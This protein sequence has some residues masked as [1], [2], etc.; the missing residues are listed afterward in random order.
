MQDR[1]WGMSEI[2]QLQAENITLKK[3]LAAARIWLY[4][5]RQKNAKAMKQALEALETAWENDPDN[6]DGYYFDAAS[7]LREALADHTEQHLEMVDRADK[8]CEAN[9]VWTDHHPDCVRAEQPAQ[10]TADKSKLET[11]PANGGLLPAQQEENLYAYAGVQIWVGNTQAS[12][13]ISRTAIENEAVKGMCLHIAA[14]WCL[15]ELKERT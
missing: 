4:I 1:G 5:E 15:Q 2:E 8:F 10:S 6:A 14:D 12:H 11:V 7:A 13:F 3:E 9:C